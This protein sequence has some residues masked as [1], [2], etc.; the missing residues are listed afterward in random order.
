MCVDLLMLGI[1]QKVSSQGQLPKSAIYQ[2]ANSQWLGNCT[3]E[4]LTLWEIAL[5]KLTLW[6][7]PF[8]K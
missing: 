3:F 6:K 2:V 7:M 1:F 5:E 4:K 8:G